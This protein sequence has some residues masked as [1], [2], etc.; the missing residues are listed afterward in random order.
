MKA[1]WKKGLEKSRT[2]AGGRAMSNAEKIE[3]RGPDTCS[4]GK[5]AGMESRSE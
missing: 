3:I 2:A 1:Q 4:G 5:G